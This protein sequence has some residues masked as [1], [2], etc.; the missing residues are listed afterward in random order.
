MSV[1]AERGRFQW[2]ENVLAFAVLVCG[3]IAAY[4]TYIEGYFPQPFFYDP[5]DTFRDWFST[6]IWARDKGAYDSWFSVY[7]PL[8]FVLLKYLGV[9]SCYQSDA[10][11]SVRD[12]DWLG[13]WLIHIIY[14]V[15][16]VIASL[17]FMRVD[18]KTAFPRAFT[19]TAGMPMLFGLERG[20]IILLCITCVML[21]WG[22]LVR[23]VHLRWTFIG[24]AVNFKVYLVG[25]VLVQL[26]RR[27]WLWVE[28]GLIAIV[29]VYL[30][31]FALFG[32][33]TPGEIVFN[34]FN[35]AQGFYSSEASVVSI[36]YNSSYNPL[37]MVLT[38][39]SAPVIFLLGDTFVDRI[40]LA[41]LLV[42]RVSQ[43]LVLVSL[44]AAWI[45]PEVVTPHRLTILGLGFIM[46]TQENPPYALPILFFF[47]F[48]ERWKGW[49]VPAAIVLTYLLSLPGEIS[50]GSSVWLQQYSYISGRSVL[51]E[52]SLGLGMFLRPMGLVLVVSLL[53]WDSILAVVRDV[54][55]DGWQGRW[56]FRQ[57][58]PV[59]PRVRRPLDPARRDAIGEGATA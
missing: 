25:A 11:I 3:L 21:G 42:M 31:S 55:E 13:M 46:I 38:E 18:R 33:G 23:S 51:T 57:D 19:L 43:L 8:N 54:R 10:G 39:S 56:R 36:W 49:L 1:P 44:V 5:D 58:A 7:P 12:C 32:E 15:N 45:R 29:L 59:L 14:V 52:R 53:A 37:Y 6:A 28:G 47:V 2:V 26:V 9:P 35:F 22:P 20:N 30:V 4:N 48:M 17:A 50:L 27:R 40:A 34:L 16:A 41:V 24:L